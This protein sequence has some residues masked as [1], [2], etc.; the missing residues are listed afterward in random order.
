M[1]RHIFGSGAARLPGRLLAASAAIFL[2]LASQSPSR[3]DG[4]PAGVAGKL[5]EA[6]GKLAALWADPAAKT[7]IIVEFAMPDLPDAASFDTPQAADEALTTMIHSA[8]DAIFGAWLGSPAAVAAAEA[9]PTANL[10]RMAYTPLFGVVASAED[11][12]KLSADSRVLRIHEDRISDPLLIQSRSLIGMDNAYVQGATGNNFHVAILDTGGRRSH[13]FLSGRI[14]SAACYSTTD[15]VNGSTSLCPGQVPA[16]TVINS[17]PDCDSSSAT[18]CSHGTHVAG[19]AAGF[20]T[21]Q[22][23]G[24]PSNGVARDARII[25]INVF[26]LFNNQAS[27]GSK[28]APCVLSFSSDQ[29]LGLERIYTLRTTR[30]IGAVTMSLGGGQFSAACDGNPLKPIIDLL[31]AARI[32]T[33]IAAGNDGFDASVGAPGCISSAITVAS[34]TKSNVRSGFSNW[35][36]L[37]DVVAPGSDILSSYLNGGNTY[38][39][40]NGTSTAAPHVAG[41]ITALRSARPWATIDQ[42]EAALESTGLGIASAGVT[43]PRI[44]VDLALNALPPENDNFAGRTAKVVGTTTGSNNNATAETGEPIHAGRANARSSVWWSYTP[45]SSGQ[46]TINT[47]G[48]SFDTVLAVYTGAAIGSLTPVASNDDIAPGNGQSRVTFQ[49][50]SGTSYAIAVAGDEMAFGAITLN[51]AFVPTPPPANDNFAN[52]IT[53]AAPG[54][55]TGSNVNATA[56]IGEPYHGNATARTSVWWRYTP[57]LSGTVVIDTLGSNFDTV[58][59]VSRGSELT[60]LSPVD[61]SDNEGGTQQSRF[62]FEATVGTSYAIAVAGVANASGAI[63]L[64]VSLTPPTPAN[65]NFANRVT[66]IV[67]RTVTG[68]NLGSTAETGEPS[69]AGVATARASVWWRIT[70]STTGPVIINTAGSGF[71]TV[72]AVYTGNAVGALT[73]VASNDNSGGTLQ[74]QVTFEALAG[75]SYAIA[76][77]GKA[78]ATGPIS[79][80]VTAPPPPPRPAND[81][82]YD[83]INIS[84]PRTVTGSNVNAT[85]QT[86]EPNH[87]GVASA[88]TSV[89]WQIRA[90]ANEQIVISTAGSGFDTVL[91]VYTGIAISDMT[92]IASN[93]DAGGTLQSQ[94]AFEATGPTYYYIAVAGKANATGTISLTVART[95]R[96]AN[97]NFATRV[98]LAALGTVSASNASAT[99]EIG[100]P[101][102]AG[103]ATRTSVWW[104]ITPSVTHP[105]VIRTAGSSFDTVLAVYTGNAVGA[106]TPV[107]SNDDFGGTLQSQVVFEATAG[108]SYA[109]AV[110][111]KANTSGPIALA[112]TRH[113]ANQTTIFSAVSPVA[114]A[115]VVGG[116]V[117]A[118]ASVINGGSQPALSCSIGV[119]GG[120]PL[121]FSYRSRNQQTGALGPANQPVNVAVGAREDFVMFFTPTGAIQQ[122]LALIFD[123]ANTAPANSVL[124]LNT[125]LLTG[126][127]GPAPADLISIAV[128]PTN[129]GIMNVPLGGTGFAALA[130]L[131]IGGPATIQAR[132]SASSILSPTTSLP[133]TMVVCQTNATTG[134]CLAPPAA[135]V[136]FTAPTGQIV[137]MTAFVASN[138]TAI[139]FDPA[140]K[141]LFVHFFQ[142]TVPVGSASVAARTVAADGVTLAAK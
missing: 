104:R 14:V 51:V 142:G 56:E 75:T 26:S 68:T 72:L 126:T 111:G 63:T 123:C 49:G 13:E 21:N 79:L 45:T 131:N 5:V 73:P 85:P 84:Y 86:G 122:E 30:N 8:Q 43:K 109:I 11:V 32:A 77:A 97:D 107:A 100:E 96:P 133:A 29:I 129:D 58:L 23:A 128:T 47:T 71:D 10:K 114:R 88:R 103:V 78:N 39:S 28:P 93:D 138:G 19:I 54:T 41:A 89:W 121:T 83:R 91:A 95:P 44:R 106:L 50:T 33:V 82:H 132:L 69:H 36:T 117:T 118:F 12:E 137:T 7:P 127:T 87:A 59:A 110:A 18:G 20:N 42:I 60:S 27:C 80:S 64:T 136:S 57:S 1:L 55:V 35:G 113:P 2:A 99:A 74:S 141:R 40:L 38:A 70:L 31:R 98:T 112:V 4:P 37:V 46:V 48:S 116:E 3:A 61:Y 17:A 67:P 81:D 66:I 101:N 94:V 102:H 105:I 124:G 6:S 16:S 120:R 24:E 90:A 9:S 125:F 140:G 134:A 53:I 139:P 65:D 115:T 62:S 108:V 34:S 135:T 25:S 52:R 130:A 15:P 76:V 119:P 22:Q 92:L